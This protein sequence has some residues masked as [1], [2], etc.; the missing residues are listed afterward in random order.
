VSPAS[1]AVLSLVLVAV[2]AFFVAS[3]FAM[4]AAKRHRLVERAERGS[5]AARSALR[6]LRELSLMLAGAQ[7]G[8]TLCTLGIGQ[9]AEPLLEHAFKPLFTL[10]GLP[11]TAGHVLSFVVGLIVVTFLHM[12]IGEMV[13]KSWVIAHPEASALIMAP[14][15][16]GFTW[17]VR[18]ALYVLNAL[19]NGL[20][21]IV[22]VDP[23]EN[24][25]EHTDPA[26]LRLLIAE[27]GRLGLIDPS[28]RTLLTRALETQTAP[29]RPLLV[30]RSRIAMVSQIADADTIQAVSRRTGHHRLLVHGRTR[31]QV[32]GVLHVRDA[33]VAQARDRTIT[34]ADLARPVPRITM[35]TPVPEAVELLRQHRTTLAAV[36]EADRLVGLASLHDLMNALLVGGRPQSAA[37]E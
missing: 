27:S 34:A 7:L 2:N 15:F 11:D 8:I 31:D 26:Q 1:A 19:A 5:R 20:L 30:P 35:R 24:L 10:V 9:V 25:E 4:V 17:L 28:E 37:A 29:I 13:P 32:V 12:V 36:I 23:R 21:R 3:E 22:H 18:P 16:R 6:G 14:P 33:V